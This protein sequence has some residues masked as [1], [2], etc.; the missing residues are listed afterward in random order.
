MFQRF[1]RTQV[2][3]LHLS[4]YLMLLRNL[5]IP[6]LHKRVRNI[7]TPDAHEYT[8]TIFFSCHQIKTHRSR[9]GEKDHIEE[10]KKVY[11]EKYILEAKSGIS[12]SHL[13]TIR[14][15]CPLCCTRL[16]MAP[17]GKHCIR[18]ACTSRIH[19][20]S[21]EYKMAGMLQSRTVVED[22]TRAVAK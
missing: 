12:V 6:I 9:R 20:I 17:G 16:P 18:S 7:F 21:L 14:D 15:I 2:N 8:Y 11:V 5:K 22:L 4:V 1:L 19:K 10:D 13:C 3:F